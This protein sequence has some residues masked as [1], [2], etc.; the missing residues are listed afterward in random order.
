MHLDEQEL[1]LLARFFAKRFPDPV[2]RAP[3]LARAGLPDEGLDTPTAA[4]EQ[5]LRTAQ[6]ENTLQHLGRAV[7]IDDPDDENLREVRR[8]LM[9]ERTRAWRPYAVLGAAGA[10]GLL[11][12]AGAAWGLATTLGDEDPA[13]TPEQALV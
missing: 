9:G 1:L 2:D 4:W 8:L 6:D 7:R 12:A 5:I 13:D 3:I 10:A 11:F